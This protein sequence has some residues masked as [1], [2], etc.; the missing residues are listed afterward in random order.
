M[1]TLTAL[2]AIGFSENEAKTYLAL[3]ADYPSTGYQISKN[4]GIPRSMIYEILAQ[5]NTRGAVLESS[6]GRATLYR[7]IDPSIL[8]SEHHQNLIET[9]SNLRSELGQIYSARQDQ[10]VWA[11]TDLDAIYSYARQMISQATSEI[12]LI[13]NDFHVETLSSTVQSSHDSG[14]PIHILATGTKSFPFANTAYHPPLESEIQG[15]SETLVVLTDQSE[16]LIAQ[17]SVIPNATI[18]NNPNLVLISRQFIWM[19]FFTQRIYSQIG[20][21]LLERLAPDDRIIFQS[22]GTSQT[23]KDAE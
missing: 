15:I 18:T 16:V 6:E 1:S 8:L 14:I 4:T 7:P 17:T 20:K 10:R 21:D 5:L 3:L 19:E 9:L 12:Y 13:A 23:Q 22:L 11:L 2:Q